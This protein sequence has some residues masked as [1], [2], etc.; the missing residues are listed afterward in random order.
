[1]SVEGRERSGA[2]AF[3]NESIIAHPPD[4]V[5]NMVLPKLQ[6]YPALIIGENINL[7]APV[8]VSR[9]GV[10]CGPTCDRRF[11][12]EVGVLHESKTVFVVFVTAK[13][14]KNLW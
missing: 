3:E 2:R 6:K 12:I 14:P 11:F 7:L 8:F 1:M 13:A 4:V 10:G 5:K 9:Q